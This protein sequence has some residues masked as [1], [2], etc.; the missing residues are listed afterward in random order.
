MRLTQQET[1]ERTRPVPSGPIVSSVSR[2][3][4]VDH[5][6]FLWSGVL[7]FVRVKRIILLMWSGPDRVLITPGK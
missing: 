3:L 6:I 5:W 4:L 1:G 7:F 2:G